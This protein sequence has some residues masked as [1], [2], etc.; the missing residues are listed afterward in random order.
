MAVFFRIQY[1][2]TFKSKFFKTGDVRFERISVRMRIMGE[3]Q[4]SAARTD[5][6]LNARIQRQSIQIFDFIDTMPDEN[7]GF[8]SADLLFTNDVRRAAVPII[9]HAPERPIGQ[10]FLK[11]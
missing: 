8:Q 4:T 6:D 7:R 5:V 10:L 11:F 3:D 9:E 2:R 1:D